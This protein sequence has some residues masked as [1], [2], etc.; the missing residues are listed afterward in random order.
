MSPNPIS[1]RQKA[2]F[3]FI[4]AIGLFIASGAAVYFS[5]DR[6]IASEGWVMHT[7][8]VQAAID[9]VDAAVARVGRAR[10][11]YVSTGNA[12]FLN[13]FNDAVGKAPE[14]LQRLRQMTA[15][16]PVQQRF[17]DRLDAVV[18]QRLG[19][20]QQAIALRK[21]NPS[22]LAG[23]DELNRQTLPLLSQS[24][25]VTRQMQA[26]EARQL[27]VRQV[28]TRR[29]QIAVLILLSFSFL[30]ALALFYWQFVLLSHELGA[31]QAAEE[32]SSNLSVKLLHLQDDERR[33]FA[34][35][36]HDSVGQSLVGI[37]MSFGRL[38]ALHR[39]DPTYQDCI[40]QL[41]QSIA[42]IRTL[43]HLLH[44]PGL[45]EGGFQ[46]AARWY[47]DE[48]ARRS[49]IRITCTISESVGRLSPA[50]ELMLMRVLQEALGNIHKHSKSKSAEV[51][52][53][54]NS[55]TAVF[56]VKDQGVGVHPD[57]LER[58][59][60]SGLS[61]VGWAGMQGR[62]RELG[63]RFR[64]ESSRNGTVIEVTL[65]LTPQTAAI[66]AGEGRSS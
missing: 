54:M 34:R 25:E 5:A 57:V 16:N 46:A 61:G 14:S 15:D 40:T 59:R 43:S 55:E 18:M 47:V 28:R 42:E 36:L 19:V 20:Y 60:Q 38:A 35:E 6:F 48:F 62:A 53:M 50:A 52:L 3:A 23:Q 9:N 11:G 10:L 51:H 17:C 24:G 13:D 49:G 41:D 26:E 7:H 37:K 39:E 21:T 22:D 66:L 33:K 8:E 31:R 56:V 4:L 45:D 58:F 32:A 12:V 1:A 30:L 27:A 44:P 63:G 29:L 2:R 64:V 65:P